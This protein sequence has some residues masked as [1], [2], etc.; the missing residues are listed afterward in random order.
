[1]AGRASSVNEAYARLMIAAVAIANALPL[2]TC[3]RADFSGIEGIEVV[4]APHPDAAPTVP[5]QP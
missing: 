4:A 5:D 2:Y 1:V 3:N